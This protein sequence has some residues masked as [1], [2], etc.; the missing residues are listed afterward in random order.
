MSCV[1]QYYLL[2]FTGVVVVLGSCQ[3]AF[4]SP[5]YHSKSTYNHRCCCCFQVPH[6][7][8]FNLKVFILVELTKFLNNDVPVCKDTRI[9]Q[10]V[11][12]LFEVFHHDVWYVRL[13]SSIS[14]YREIPEDR[15]IFS[16]TTGW[17]VVLKQISGY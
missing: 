13:D 4:D 8:N 7:A 12:L 3:D 1:D 15:Y 6:S 9:Y 17:G 5:L 14:V 10:E 16:S 11:G 2:H